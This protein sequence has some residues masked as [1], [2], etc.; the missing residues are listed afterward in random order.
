MTN[1][2]QITDILDGIDEWN[3]VQK[4][5]KQKIFHYPDDLLVISVASKRLGM[6]IDHIMK[7][8]ITDEDRELASK[9]KTFY[10]QKL[11]LV[12]L[13][14]GSL[15]KFRTALHKFLNTEKMAFPDNG[16][17]IYTENYTGMAISLPYMYEVDQ[18]LIK[19]FENYKMPDY[20]SIRKTGH[21]QLSKTGQFLDYR[22]RIKDKVKFLKS[23]NDPIKKECVFWFSD[24]EET[25]LCLRIS[26]NNELLAF[27]H[28]MIGQSTDFYLTSE[29]IPRTRDG[30]VFLEIY[31]LKSL[32]PNNLRWNPA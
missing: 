25:R 10:N 5:C 24:A 29:A 8:D 30:L 3:E 18:H 27:F 2:N 26:N 13:R 11:V 22:S 16:A 31:N 28:E 1:I 4:S 7:K 15:T 9:I 23:Y 20:N 14:E 12:S 19:I 21:L 32:I 17:Y 6:H